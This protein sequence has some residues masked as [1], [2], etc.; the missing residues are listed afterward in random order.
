VVHIVFQDKGQR[1]PNEQSRD[2][3]NT[4]FKKQNEDKDNIYI[5]LI[6][7]KIDYKFMWI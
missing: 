7:L 3:C 2:T 5:I 6:E 1:K 4:G